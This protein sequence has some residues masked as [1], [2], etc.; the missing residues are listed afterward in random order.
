MGFNIRLEDEHGVVAEQIDDPRGLLY[1]VLPEQPDGSYQYLPFIDRYG[2]TV[3]NRPQMKP[4][5]AEW[6]RLIGECSDVELRHLLN[7]V[8]RL[9]AS[10][11][12]GVHLYLRFVGE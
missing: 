4:F 6:S 5:I 9:A 2:D 7:A 8:R 3:F 1:K 11:E 12:E 10:C